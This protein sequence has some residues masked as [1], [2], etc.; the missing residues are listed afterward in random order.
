MWSLK[1]TFIA[2]SVLLSLEFL[3][4]A[5]FIGRSFAWSHPYGPALL[6]AMPS[7]NARPVGLD[8]A[9]KGDGSSALEKDGETTSDSGCFLA[10]THATQLFLRSP[11]V[12]PACFKLIITPKVS[13]CIFKS[14][15]NL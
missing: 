3:S 10:A 8:S 1:K 14:V 15:L 11:A 13:R 5:V 12:V 9:A 2:G 6:T 7:I 4:L